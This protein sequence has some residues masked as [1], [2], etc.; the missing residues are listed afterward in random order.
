MDTHNLTSNPPIPAELFEAVKAGNLAIVERCVRQ[1]PKWVH[2]VIPGCPYGET[3]LHYAAYNGHDRL[4]AFL[5]EMKAEVNATGTYS[6][7][8]PLH[9]AAAGGH[10]GTFSSHSCSLPF[11]T[12]R[13][14]FSNLTTLQ[15]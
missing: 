1:Q 10:L 13:V 9:S 5:I 11:L 2:E 14:L 3:L 15:V 8:T 4:A 7:S 6:G 12:Q